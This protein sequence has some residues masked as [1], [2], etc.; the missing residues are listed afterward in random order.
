MDPTQ[1]WK[2]RTLRSF[3]SV[4]TTIGTLLLFALLSPSAGAQWPD[5]PIRLVVPA[6]PASTTDL[7]GRVLSEE[8]PKRLGQ[9][10][11]VDNRP[12]GG[13]LIGTEY[14]LRQPADG[15][16]FLLTQNT[17]VTIVHMS[18]KPPYDPLKDFEPVSLIARTPLVL[19]VNAN[20]SIK[21]V[22]DFVAAARA[23]NLKYGSPGIGTP[24]HLSMVQLLARAGV[25]MTHVPYKG[26]GPIAVAL[27]GGEIDATISVV[28]AV[29]PY[30]QSGRIR[31]L[32]VSGAS[33]SALLPDLPT[34]AESIPG[35]VLEAWYALLAPRGTPRPI[36][37]RM[38]EEISS[39]LSDP[40]LVKSRLDA[41]GVEP[42]GTSPEGLA[43]VLRSDNERYRTIFQEAGITP[44]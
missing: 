34:V 18:Q 30:I 33:R 26:S 3:R 14:V 35:V 38:S 22:G 6:P 13:T 5:K 9:T 7:L 39:I 8:L 40:A 37:V 41:S 27:V 4:V 25:K 16:T 28:G 20:S 21:S 2:H 42:V 44:R 12:G 15:N 10:V 43:D 29:L 11:L 19:A 32:A 23:G 31:A 17:L 24:Q 36:V 1:R